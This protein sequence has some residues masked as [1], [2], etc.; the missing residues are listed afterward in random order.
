MQA[1][2]AS[3]LGILTALGLPCAAQAQYAYDI[4]ALDDAQFDFH[5]TGVNN[6]GQVSGYAYVA[7][8]QRHA[9]YYTDG[10]LNDVAPGFTGSSAGIKINDQGNM[11]IGQ[12]FYNVNTHQANDIPGLDASASLRDINQHGDIL[13]DT[14]AGNDSK[15]FVYHSD[16]GQIQYLSGPSGAAPGSSVAVAIN[17]N[18]IAVGS[19]IYSSA[20]SGGHATLYSNGIGQDLGNQPNGLNT[21]ATGI[22]DAGDLCGYSDV[23]GS[24][25]GAQQSFLYHNG[26]Y[27]NIGTF[28]NDVNGSIYAYGISND[29]DVV[30]GTLLHPFIYHNGQLSNLFNLIDPSLGWTNGSAQAI[31]DQ[32]WIVGYGNEGGFLMK[33]HAAATPAPGSLLTFGAG[34]FSV[35]WLA[36]RRLRKSC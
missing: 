11:L 36:R 3:L 35:R 1:R 2:F 22:N 12:G 14:V 29:G 18:G 10:Q 5:P 13:G 26:Q 23:F 4:T 27:I 8:G 33:P 19:S 30:G 28:P 15:P 17:N 21:Q 25:S 20:N 31:N 7:S 16:T 34:M 9:F 6:V 32:G 24:A